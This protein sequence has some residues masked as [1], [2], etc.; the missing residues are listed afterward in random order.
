[1]KDV[2]RGRELVRA[3]APPAIIVQK[4]LLARYGIVSTPDVIAILFF[5][6]ETSMVCIYFPPAALR[7]GR[8]SSKTWQPLFLLR[9][10]CPV[11]FVGSNG[12][13]KTHIWAA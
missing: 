5:M 9:V 13:L 7:R 1:M 3:M 6:L 11:A 12:R 10:A 8:S 4:K 2:H